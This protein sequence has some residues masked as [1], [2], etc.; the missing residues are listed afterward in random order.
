[1]N[2]YKMWIGGRW[3]EAES[4]KTFSVINPASG[5]K[6]TEVPLGDKADVDKAVK[7]AQL[8]FP[9]WSRKPQVER[10]KIVNQISVAL[11][12]HLQEFAQLETLEHG[13]PIRL[14]S[15]FHIPVAAQCFEYYAQASRTLMGTVVPVG[16][17]VLSY[18]QREPIGVCGLITP[19]NFPLTMVS[20]KLGPALAVGNT[21]VVKPPSI[22]PLTTLK[23]AEILEK[24]D[25]PPGTVNIIT[26]PGNTVGEILASHPGIY[27]I[28]FT[29]SCETGKRIMSCEASN[30]RRF[31]MEL[32]GKNPFI[33]LEDADI[34]SAVEGAIFGSFFNSGMVCASVGKYFVHE[35]CHDEFVEKF[36]NAARSIVAGDPSDA[37]TDM[38]PLV[39]ADHRDKVEAYIKSAIAEGATLVL[40]G[41]RP[42]KPPMDH[43]YY[44]MPTIFTNVTPQMKVAREEIYGPVACVMKFSSD[45]QVVDLANDSDF[46]LAASLWTRNTVKGIKY[47]NAIKAGFIWI[48]DNV[49]I[50]PELP[51]GGFKESGFGKDNSIHVFDEYT[52]IKTIWVDLTETKK[53]PWYNLINPR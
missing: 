28:G 46:G 48:N 13:A 5:K 20:W 31:N 16:P 51:W 44:V 26:G 18:T 52:Q 22:A 9:E 40:G 50:S 27:K 24:L 34:D 53:K 3:V 36:V 10:S 35:R 17:H 4:G 21:C 25:L 14:A 39:S 41:E 49:I 47:A 23:L 38:G 15:N 11:M 43:G 12:E 32:G 1:M 8:A 29:G 7:A 6:I 42:I 37:K 19:W 2:S 33:I 45:D 30:I